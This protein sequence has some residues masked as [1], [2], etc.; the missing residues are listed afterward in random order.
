MGGGNVT[1]IFAEFIKG[2]FVLD[3]R[4]KAVALRGFRARSF[5]P[6]LGFP[7][8]AHG[9]WYVCWSALVGPISPLKMRPL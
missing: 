1:Y 7:Y 9:G 2:E 8:L 3:R 6:G 4:R 5:G